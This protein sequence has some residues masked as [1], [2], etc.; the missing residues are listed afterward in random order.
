MNPSHF[1]QLRPGSRRSTNG[2]L[3]EANPYQLADEQ[4][5]H[6][7]SSDDDGSFRLNSSVE[8]LVAVDDVDG[9]AAVLQ[10]RR[11]IGRSSGDSMHMGPVAAATFR[12]SPP[13][14]SF[15]D[16]YFS[17]VLLRS[18]RYVSIRF[19]YGTGS[20]VLILTLRI[21]IL[22]IFQLC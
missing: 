11:K 1:A 10:V 5:Q 4:E 9:P 2:S 3:P 16:R 17:L 8:H 18:V 7:T 20:R 22:L 15:A 14:S 13:E 6:L 12:P 21:R 19:L